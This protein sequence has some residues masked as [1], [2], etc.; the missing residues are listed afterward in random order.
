M[1]AWIDGTLYP[2]VDPPLVI[3]WKIALTFLSGFVELGI[4]AYCPI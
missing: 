1:Q 2:D 3:P 4:L